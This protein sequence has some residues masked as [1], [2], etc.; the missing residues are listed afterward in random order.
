MGPQACGAQDDTS[1]LVGVFSGTKQLGEEVRRI[2]LFMC[3]EEQKQILR[4]AYPNYVWAPSCS[5]QDD[6]SVL[7]GVFGMTAVV[8]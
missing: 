6:T 3:E 1:V 2:L 4:S 7:V 8:P 5:A